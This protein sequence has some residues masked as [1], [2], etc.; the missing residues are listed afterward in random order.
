MFDRLA[1]LNSVDRSP[2]PSGATPKD[3]A[4][5]LLIDKQSSP[6]KVLMGKRHQ[7]NT[8]MPDVYVFPGGAL[9]QSDKNQ[10]TSCPP[11]IQKQRFHF[12]KHDNETVF[13]TAL[14]WCALRET[15]EETELD[16]FANFGFQTHRN[17]V[18]QEQQSWQ[19]L[20]ENCVFLARAIT[21]PSNKKRFDTRFFIYELPD[22]VNKQ[23]QIGDELVD[24]QWVSFQQA[25]SLN[26]HVMTRVILEDLNDYM[27]HHQLPEQ[28]KGVI[29][30]HM[31]DKSFHRDWLEITS[32][33]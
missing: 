18:S 12:L 24:L 13:Q 7:N 9:E 15:F 33:P 20:F 26:L 14:L 31:V 32:T 5:L 28:P 4:S 27:K 8:F 2:A 29:F 11:D 21:P 25:L 6:Y 19:N 3:A 23:A 1:H 10:A 22:H 17:D 16:L 30:Y